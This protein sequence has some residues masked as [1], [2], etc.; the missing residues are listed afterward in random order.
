MPRDALG[1]LI[2]GGDLDELLRHVDRLCAARDWEGLLELRDR[3]RKA[4]ERGRQLWPVASHAEYRLALEAPGPWAAGVLLPGAG[5]FALGPLPEVAAAGH[6]W[7]EL[8]P[9]LPASPEAT[10]TAHERVV[11][12]EDLTGDGRVDPAVLEVP[13]RLQAWEPRYPVA[14]Y[15]ASEAQFPEGPLPH[16]GPVDLD[17]AAPVTEDPDATAALVELAGA[18]TTESNGRARAVAVAGAAPGAV[19]ALLLRSGHGGRTGLAGAR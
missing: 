7:A 13:L 16:L 18:W 9:H 4:L 1:E 2:E 17:G 11:R 10:F 5:R 12:G 14:V 8:A 19:A 15:K 6:T 3:A